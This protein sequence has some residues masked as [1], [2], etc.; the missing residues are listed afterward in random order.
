MG[1]LTKKRPSPTTVIAMLALFLAVGGAT[2]IALPGTNSVDS[3]DIRNGQVKTKDLRNNSVSSAKVK[4]DTLNGGDINES[5][6]ST[7]PSANNANNADSANQADQATNAGTVDGDDADDLR[8]SS[9]FNS[10]ASVIALTSTLT[11]YATA[12]IT[13]EDAQRIIA[14]GS[15]E[16]TGAESDERAQCL[17][18]IDGSSSLGYETTF[19]D[20]GTSNETTVAV[21]HAVTR[22]PGTYNAALRCDELTGSVVKDDAAIAVI[23]VGS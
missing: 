8:T 17:I 10:N 21:T 7:V 12:N 2:A 19:D 5:S 6:L 20:I 15:V 13:I 3:G 4:P 23:G 1:D 22:N 18:T 9:A 14:T 11:T 16:L